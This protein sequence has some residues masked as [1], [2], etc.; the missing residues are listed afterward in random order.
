MV[1]TRTAQTPIK[2]LNRGSNLA[3]RHEIIEELGR[4]RM[5]NVYRV[6]DKKI[7]EE[8]GS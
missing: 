4:G 8:E 6:L 7:N 1:R 2:E 3:G 5:G